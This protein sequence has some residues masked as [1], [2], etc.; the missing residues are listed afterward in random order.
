MASLPPVWRSLDGWHNPSDFAPDGRRPLLQDLNAI[1][2]I[3][4]IRDSRIATF[5][6]KLVWAR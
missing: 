3:L 4:A 5:A 2:A 6:N 1:A